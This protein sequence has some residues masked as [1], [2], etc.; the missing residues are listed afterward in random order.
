LVSPSRWDM[1]NQ[2]IFNTYTYTTGVSFLLNKRGETIK[3][4]GTGYCPS[5]WRWW[6][7]RGQLGR[8]VFTT[9]LWCILQIYSSRKS[10]RLLQTF[11]YQ[12]NFRILYFFVVAMYTYIRR[13]CMNRM[14]NRANLLA[15]PFCLNF[16]QQVKNLQGYYIIWKERP[17]QQLYKY[18]VFPII[19]ISSSSLFDCLSP[20]I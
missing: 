18:F 11:W 8:F 1:Q 4:A 5:L 15:T 12:A 17:I 10:S 3:E 9:E 2:L 20:F 14:L 19:A 6:S 7:I 16:Q 13:S